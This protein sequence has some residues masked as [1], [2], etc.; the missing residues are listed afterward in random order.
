[1]ERL[2]GLSN[3]QTML[4]VNCGDSNAHLS[5]VEPGDEEM[6]R[7]YGLAV[8]AGTFF[9]KKKSHKITYMSGR[10]KT[11][12]PTIGGAETAAQEGEGLQSVGGRIRHYTA[13]TGLL[14]GP[15]EGVE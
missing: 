8:R 7:R 6:F 5:V 13:Q 11:A 2:A 10:H 1:M 3:G 14:R 4:C 12:R 15:H 9:H